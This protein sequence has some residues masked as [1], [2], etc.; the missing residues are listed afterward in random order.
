MKSE[1]KRCRQ[2]DGESRLP[3][4]IQGVEFVTGSTNFKLHLIKRHQLLSISGMR[5]SSCRIAL[6]FS[7]CLSVYQTGFDKPGRVACA[8]TQRQGRLTAAHARCLPFS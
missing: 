7:V 3:E 1:Q 4:I 8:Q 2:R 5:G 6:P